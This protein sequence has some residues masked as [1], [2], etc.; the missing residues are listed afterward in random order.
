[1]AQE[2]TMEK[3]SCKREGCVDQPERTRGGRVYSP[4]VDIVELKDELLMLADVPGV[5]AEDVEIQYEQGQLTLHARVQPRQNGGRTQYLAR[6]YGIGDF[7]R[8]FQIG[9]GIDSQRIEA[10]LKD[11]VLTLH[12]PKAEA[13]RPRR[14]QVKA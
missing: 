12:L 2:A 13:V 10:E 7:Y 5:K 6:E 9:E 4:S 3:V 14:I 1:M 8:S 11:G